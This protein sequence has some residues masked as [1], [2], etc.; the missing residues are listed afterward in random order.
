MHV[1]VRTLIVFGASVLALFA[2]SVFYARYSAQHAAQLQ[3]PLVV[4]L[5]DSYQTQPPV[6]P[7][8]KLV[9]IRVHDLRIHLGCPKESS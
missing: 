5:D 9:A 6:T 1:S 3:C 2:A 8:G 4:T 7:A